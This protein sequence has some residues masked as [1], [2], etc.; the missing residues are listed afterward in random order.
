MNEEQIIPAIA[1]TLGVNPEVAVGIIQALGTDPQTFLT[2]LQGLL[3]NGDEGMQKIQSIIQ[4]L[5]QSDFESAQQMYAS[6]VDQIGSQGGVQYAKNGGILSSYCPPG[7]K[8]GYAKDGKKIC[9]RC[10]KKAQKGEDG[11]EVEDPDGAYSFLGAIPNGSGYAV[12]PYLKQFDSMSD[13]EIGKIVRNRMANGQNPYYN[14]YTNNENGVNRSFT[15]GRDGNAV[16][17]KYTESSTQQIP[18]SEF[19]KLL[20]E[21]FGKGKSL[22]DD[23]IPNSIK[24]LF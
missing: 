18:S 10:Q 3:Q 14:T 16:F 6:I 9:K 17:S 23:L 2:V 24:K 4:A 5:Q 20:K 11:L 13:E 22:F 15:E 19:N 1:N 21:K 12:D 8:V 7:T